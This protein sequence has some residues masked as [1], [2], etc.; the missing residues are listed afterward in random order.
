MS[1]VD[2][3]EQKRF[4]RKVKNFDEDISTTTISITN[5]KTKILEITP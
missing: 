4:G 5:I 2:P 3:S 1:A